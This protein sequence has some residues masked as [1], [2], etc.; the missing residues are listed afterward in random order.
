MST[1]KQIRANSDR[2]RRDLETIEAE[3]TEARNTFSALMDGANFDPKQAEALAA[4]V[5]VLETRHT[6]TAA[7][8]AKNEKSGEH[9]E[10]LMR[11][12]EY[13]GGVKRMAELERFFLEEADDVHA[14]MILIRERLVKAR[15]A[16]AEYCDLVGRYCLDLDAIAQTEKIRNRDYI[17]LAGIA[18]WLERQR[19]GEEFTKA[20]EAMPTPAKANGKKPQPKR[21]QVFSPPALS[22]E[23]VK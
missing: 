20:L 21:E 4:R 8:L 18:Q 9:I 13:K 22:L 11:S 19:K 15:D 17:Y 6:A 10:A 1:P 23:D 12:K 2:L 3:L 14:E 7:A 5:M 16:H